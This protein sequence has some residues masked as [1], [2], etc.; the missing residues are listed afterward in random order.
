MG[1]G[2]AV[3]DV[4]QRERMGAKA[5]SFGKLRMV[6][7]QQAAQIPL[8]ANGN[9][10]RFFDLRPLLVAGARNQRYLQLWCGAA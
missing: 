8:G 3:E 5:T 4:T 7:G 1:A 2:R 10:H 6:A 9:G